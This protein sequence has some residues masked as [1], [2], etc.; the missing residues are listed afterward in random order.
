MNIKEARHIAAR[1]WCDP[2]TASKEMDAELAEVFAETLI[3]HRANFLEDGPY[4]LDCSPVDAIPV[5]VF[6]DK[7]YTVR[8]D[9]EVILSGIVGKDLAVKRFTQ[10]NH[11]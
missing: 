6:D 8:V 11:E 1:C 4:W 3:A 2:R 10:R 9:G 7:A 5:N